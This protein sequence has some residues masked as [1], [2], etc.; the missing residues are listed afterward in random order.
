VSRLCQISDANRRC[1]SNSHSLNANQLKKQMQTNNNILSGSGQET[2]TSSSDLGAKPNGSADAKLQ[3]YIEV[4]LQSGVKYENAQELAS[5]QLTDVLSFLANSLDNNK[6]VTIEEKKDM[7]LK[8]ETAIGNFILQHHRNQECDYIDVVNS[9]FQVSRK[10]VFGNGGVSENETYI[11]AM[12]GNHEIIDGGHTYVAMN[13]MQVPTNMPATRS[14][15]PNN[16]LI[17]EESVMPNTHSRWGVA[18]MYQEGLAAMESGKD[19]GQYISYFGRNNTD[20]Y[21]SW[22]PLLTANLDMRTDVSDIY[23]KLALYTMYVCEGNVTANRELVD[24]SYTD[25]VERN[26]IPIDRIPWSNPVHG[27]I[28][29][30]MTLNISKC[31]LGW[32]LSKETQ[33]NGAAVGAGSAL[34]IWLRNPASVIVI[35]I[36][37]NMDI[38][39]EYIFCHLRYPWSGAMFQ[40]GVSFL[41]GTSKQDGVGGYQSMLIHNAMM[42]VIGQIL[43]NVLFVDVLDMDKILNNTTV[44]FDGAL[45]NVPPNAQVNLN[46]RGVTEAG[47]INAWAQVTTMYRSSRCMV[48]GWRR[49]VYLTTR[50]MNGTGAINS[51]NGADNRFMGPGFTDTA[52]MAANFIRMGSQCL[53]DGAPIVG[54]E[55]TL[56]DTRAME[57]TGWNNMQPQM[58]L[59]VSTNYVRLAVAA[60]AIQ[61]VCAYDTSTK[62]TI[63]GISSGLIWQRFIYTLRMA[64]YCESYMIATIYN[65]MG[66][67]KD[68]VCS[69]WPVSMPNK[70]VFNTIRANFYYTQCGLQLQAGTVSGLTGLSVLG[71]TPEWDVV[72]SVDW[73]WIKNRMCVMPVSAYVLAV[74]RTAR[75]TTD[76]PYLVLRGAGRKLKVGTSIPNETLAYYA[77]DDETTIGK[78][79]LIDGMYSY[80]A[81]DQRLVA[82]N[83]GVGYVPEYG[84]GYARIV[85]CRDTTIEPTWEDIG[86]CYSLLLAPVSRRVIGYSRSCLACVIPKGSMAVSYGIGVL[87]ML[88]GFRARPQVVGASGALTSVPSN[89]ESYERDSLVEQYF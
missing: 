4:A 57:T 43:S 15:T 32:L 26:I 23:T 33:M 89:V 1:L 54:F 55:Q 74:F 70:N 53:G 76:D 52:T 39:V 78:G 67:T 44:S 59:P 36:R 18:G 48:D 38:T 82:V 63:A 77:I 41:D 73:Q 16:L 25:T 45:Q 37:G 46:P 86:N 47:I 3:S 21:S 34:D 61:S 35:P 22:M 87:A 79:S 42:V 64:R 6:P 85:K 80:A 10:T 62:F 5:S 8:T 30:P 83:A 2:T 14:D 49:A 66:I 50:H 19:L 68:H 29:T 88:S 13:N 71:G 20:H 28:N 81:W 17:A 58:V 7:A 27:A 56:A 69:R 51:P 24:A 72:D 65:S 84:I 31:T 11:G 9:T 60:Q 75:F 40:A 12:V